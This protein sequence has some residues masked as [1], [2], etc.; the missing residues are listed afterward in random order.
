M[1]II[2]SDPSALPALSFF[3]DASS[4]DSA[5]MVAGGFAVAGN[6]IN[7]IEDHIAAKQNAIQHTSPKGALADSG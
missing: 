1:A 5:Y 2:L 7:E 3:G 4:R 6:R